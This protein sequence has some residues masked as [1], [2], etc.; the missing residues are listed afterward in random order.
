MPRVCDHAVLQCLQGHLAE[1]KGLLG[2]PQEVTV[3]SLDG[4]GSLTDWWQVFRITQV[5]CWM[6]KALVHMPQAGLRTMSS[7]HLYALFNMLE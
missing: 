7:P 4:L 6:S 2:E 5:C 3:A 1:V